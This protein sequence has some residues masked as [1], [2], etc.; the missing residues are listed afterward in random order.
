MAFNLYVNA[1]ATGQTTASVTFGGFNESTLTT[2]ITLSGPG[3]ISGSTSIPLPPN[4]G[5][6]NTV[7]VSGLS[8]GTTYTWTATAGAESAQ[9]SATTDSAPPPSGTATSWTDNTLG[10]FQREVAYS[11]GVSASGTSPITYSV[12]AGTLPSGISLNSST[13]AV[14]GTP[15]VTAAYSFTLQAANS[16]GSVTQAFSG[17]V[18]E[19]PFGKIAVW[20]GSQWVKGFVN[21]YDGSAWQYGQV[22]VYNGSAWVKAE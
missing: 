20:D 19:S 1:T 3:S 11:D 5:N 22:Y 14:T 2:T 15:T 4:S 13:G 16:Y 9:G 6:S 8:A 7:T 21:V 17:S 10:G 18:A 12:S